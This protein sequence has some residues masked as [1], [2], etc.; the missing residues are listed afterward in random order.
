MTADGSA[1]GRNYATGGQADPWSAQVTVTG[2][3]PGALTLVAWTG[4]HAARI[5][6]FAVTGLRVE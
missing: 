2:A 5:E 1:G 6:W 4:G 3:H